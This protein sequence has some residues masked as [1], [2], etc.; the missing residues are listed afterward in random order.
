ML[1][2]LLAILIALL[3][4]IILG[5]PFLL[6]ALP[7]GNTRA[8]YRAGRFGAHMVLWV[9]GIKLE[10]RGR[11]KIPSGRAVV[12]MPNH[13]SNCDP[14]AVFVTL[15]PVRVLAK[16]EFFRI[17]VLGQAMKLYGFIPVDRNHRDR[18]IRA[19]QAAA[20]ALRAGHSF[21]AYPEGTRSLDGRLQP[22]K[23][24]VFVMAMD[25]GAPIIPVSI[26][27]ARRIMP[28]GS[29]AVR[30]GTLHITFHD[31]VVTQGRAPEERTAVMAE[32][33]RAIRSALADDEQPLGEV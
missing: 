18:A 7:T 5:I 10:V 24:G 16:K 14:P 15:P 33:R 26:S 11:E 22:F 31:P 6:Y 2:T 19:V 23:K 12:F 28:K 17:P 1:R 32:V 30:P 3:L 29:L 4:I 20:A 21:L 8:L 13:Q 25:A 9:S 27:G